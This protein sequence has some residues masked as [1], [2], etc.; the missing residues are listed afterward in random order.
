MIGGDAAGA[1]EIG[2]GRFGPPPGGTATGVPRSG[3]EAA[4]PPLRGSSN[5]AMVGQLFGSQCVPVRSRTVF[6]DPMRPGSCSDSLSGFPSPGSLHQSPASPAN[7]SFWITGGYAGLP[8]RLYP[9]QVS[10]LAVAREA[11]SVTARPVLWAYSPA[12]R[13]LPPVKRPSTDWV[14]RT[15]ARFFRGTEAPATPSALSGLMSTKSWSA[16]PWYRGVTPRTTRG[17]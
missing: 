5:A 3:H 13:R 2:A 4:G 11:G 1:G 6:R 9:G 15:S 14:H 7:P 8:G 10:G 16:A 17:R 12:P